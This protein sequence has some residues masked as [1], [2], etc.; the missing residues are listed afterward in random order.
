MRGEEKVAMR[1]EVV[2]SKRA[3]RMRGVSGEL[4]EVVLVREWMVTRWRRRVET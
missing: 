3:L 4:G 2:D 1:L